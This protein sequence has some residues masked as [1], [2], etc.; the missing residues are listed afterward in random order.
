MS[1]RAHVAVALLLLAGCATAN[2]AA[3]PDGVAG[4]SGV[5]AGFKGQPHCNAGPGEPIPELQLNVGGWSL[6]P[7]PEEAACFAQSLHCTIDETITPTTSQIDPGFGLYFDG[8]LGTGDGGTGRLDIG[9]P[10]GFSI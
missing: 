2:R 9:L 1:N 7:T 4:D 5:D 6:N 3:P 8:P 10:P